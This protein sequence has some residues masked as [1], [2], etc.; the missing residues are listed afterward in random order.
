[1]KL[2][3]PQPVQTILH[4]LSSHGYEAAVVGGCVR[5]SLIGLSPK[6]WDI[7]TSARP[8]EV[9]EALS[10]LK[11]LETGLKHGTITAL[12]G[13][14]AVEVTTYRIDG[15]YS[16][17]RRPDSVCFTG[18]MKEDLARRDFT[19]NAMAYSKQKGLIDCFGGQED[20]QNKILRCVGNPCRR[21]EEDALRILRGLRFCSVLGLTPEEKTSQ[22]MNEHKHLL[23]HIARERVGAE[24]V[25]LLC[26]EKAAETLRQFSEIIGQI[27]PEILPMIGFDQ[28]NPHH[29]YDVWEHTLHA[30]DSVAPDPVLRLSILLH[31]S[32]KPHT[33]TKDKKG[34]GHFYGH[35]AVSVQLAEDALH[36]LRTDN[37]TIRRVSLLIRLHDVPLQL[38]A[39][40]V[41]RRLNRMGEKDFRALLAIKRADSLAQNPIYRDRLDALAA[42]EP[43][44]EQVLAE[45][46]CFSLKQLKVNGT[47][48][49]HLG[50]P[51]GPILGELLTWL[52]NAVI[53]GKAPNDKEVLLQLAAE[54]HHEKQ[55]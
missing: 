12:S 47:D 48:L 10:G 49:Q 25:K 23:D 53:D 20:L 7:T 31:D 5:D 54:K 3:I 35:E 46:Q 28:Q 26:G 8:D 24:L 22:S 42:I 30:L 52:L 38:N 55:R 17:N 4:G 6:D 39:A 40:W 16:D 9:K 2:D 44:L 27:L 32:G 21:F 45:S 50:I 29:I 11:L 43:I 13:G 1:M 14:M 51:S 19:I 33:F 34:V 15:E 36:R 18:S 37:Q 41:R